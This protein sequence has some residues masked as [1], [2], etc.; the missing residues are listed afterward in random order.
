M[1]W[2]LKCPAPTS[3]KRHLR[4]GDF[5]FANSLKAAFE[6]LGDEVLIQLHG[7]WVEETGPADAVLVL[8][9]RHPYQR[10]PD[11]RDAM[12]VIWN[13]SHP[14]DVPFEE[15]EAYDLV[16][17]ASE[18]HAERV[19]AEIAR[20]V[21]AL[22]QCTDPSVFR[23]PPEGTDRRGIVFVGNTRSVRRDLVLWAIELGLHLRIWGGG[24]Q[25]FVDDS[26]VVAQRIANDE[27][28]ELYARAR[29]TLNDHWPDMRGN[30]FINNRIFDALAAGIVVISDRH[31]AL[32]A[33]F[34]DAVLYAGSEAEL[35]DAIERVTL[36]YPLLLDRVRAARPRIAEG[37]SFDARARTLHELVRRE[38]EH[39]GSQRGELRE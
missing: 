13:I 2:I 37:F 25:E 8:R 15:Y 26:Y 28:G 27:V 12:H 31:P 21:T 20:P 7:Q 23:P 11:T 10:R 33:L 1:R 18:Q 9:G 6:R 30:G 32:E 35:A 34:P 14:D 4:W 17:I 38:L 24:W 19:R 22:L 29:V 36:S 3:R 5:H 39:R 16:C